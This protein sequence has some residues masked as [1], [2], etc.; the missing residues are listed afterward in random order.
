[1]NALNYTLTACL[2]KADKPYYEIHDA[3]GPDEYHERVNNNAYTNRMAKFVFD[4]ALELSEKYPI[5]SELKER[6]KDSSKNILIKE[7]NASGIIEQFD[8]C[9]RAGGRKC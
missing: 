2:K 5:E 7:P 3:V 9:F 4:T 6:L 8:G 1:M